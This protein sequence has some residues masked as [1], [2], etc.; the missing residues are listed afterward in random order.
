MPMPLNVRFSE[1]NPFLRGKLFDEWDEDG[2]VVLGP[3]LR[4]AF[5]SMGGPRG[6]EIK[7]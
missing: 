1:M 3:T 7:A 4:C 2:E 6:A 5:I